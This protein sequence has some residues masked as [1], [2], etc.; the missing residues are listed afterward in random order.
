[1][2]A[3]KDLY[4]MRMALKEAKKGLGRTSPNPCV[5]A[6][7]VKDD[8]VIAKGYH[9]KAGEPHAEINALRKAGSK[10]DGAT[11]YV[12]LEPCNHTGRTS[13]CSQALVA[14]GI[15]R[16][17]V[18]M[19][20]PNPL[21]DGS[22]L[23]FLI[24]QKIEVLSGVLIEECREINRPFLKYITTSMPWVVMKA[25]VSLD[26]RITYRK[27]ESGW[28]T[29]AE[30]LRKVHQLRDT[31]DAIMVGIGTIAIDDPTLTTR[32]TSRKGKDPV[33]II[34]DSGLRIPV[35]AKVL[36]LDS[37]AATWIFCGPEADIRRK[38][39]LA[40][41]GAVVR[42]VASDPV[43]GLD[44]REV[45][46]VLGSAGITSV[47]VEG[48]AKVH[49]SMLRNRLVDHVNLFYAPL[50]AGDDG[51]PVVQGLSVKNRNEAIHLEKIRYKRFGD[52]LMIEGDVSYRN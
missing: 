18:G 43:G 17:V 33:R 39:E 51:I 22:G 52:D 5:G 31:T 7:I 48:G 30:S 41:I 37:D 11:V 45:L 16:V 29:G 35:S 4:Y 40:A 25:G 38:E 21:V 26:G 42:S 44:I 6:V 46:A 8:R 13:P 36:H 9:E 34:V 47:L 20:D 50:F 1:V 12:T 32:L 2:T 3:E 10:A 24:D 23:A 15:K 49:G 19:E 28:I 27:G 14:A